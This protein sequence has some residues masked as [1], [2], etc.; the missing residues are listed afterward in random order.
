MT[1]LTLYEIAPGEHPR[2][3]PIATGIDGDFP[4]T[5]GRNSHADI[6]IGVIGRKVLVPH[7]DPKKRADGEKVSISSLISR[8]QATIFRD[9]IGRLRIRDGNSHPSAFGI[10]EFGTNKLIRRPWLLGPGAHI[11]LT[12]EGEGY[13]CGLQW[14]AEESESE[15]PTLG[16]ERWHNENLQEEL[17]EQR[18]ALKALQE[19]LNTT[20]KESS[21]INT[22]QDQRI[23]SAEKKISRLL[24]LGAIAVFIFAISLGISAEQI[25]TVVQVIAILSAVGG[26]GFILQNEKP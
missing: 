4:L 13:R 17:A 6:Q 18:A 24:L 8:V 3:I 21:E 1:Q 11:T 12:F 14:A 16:Y 22:A 20:K 25:Q 19:A 2:E 5:I 7:P 23:H 9:E 15:T 10:R 26:G